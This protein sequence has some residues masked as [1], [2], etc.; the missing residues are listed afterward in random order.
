MRIFASEALLVP[1]GVITAAFLSRQFGPVGY[2]VITLASLIVVWL[3]SNVA[4][5]FSS[6]AIKLINDAADHWQ[7]VG[8]SVIRLYLLAGCGLGL[9]IWGGATPVATLL[10]EP[11]LARYL[12]L[13]ALEIPLFCLAQAHRNIIVGLGQYQQRA[14]ASAARW[15]AR[16]VF[17]VLFVSLTGS[18]VGA[19]WGTICASFIELL[20]CRLYV[21]PSLFNSKAFPLSL[22]CSYAL[23][24]VA[25]AFCLSLFQRLDLLL[26]KLLGGS[27]SDAGLYGAAQNLA[28]LPSLFSF[29]FVPA[30][31]STLNRALRDGDEII[32]R[33]FGQQ[34]IR[35]VLLLLPLI[36]I[37]AGAAPE[38][39]GLIFGRRFI[40]AAPL[41]RL[42]IFGSLA[43]L[44][45]SVA[46]SIM[47]A[48]GKRHF[49]LCIA[50]PLLLAAGAAH[51][52]LIPLRGSLAAAAVTTTGACLGAV[53]SLAIV[54]RLW[55][56][57]LPWAT[58]GRTSLVSAAAYSITALLPNTGFLLPLKI[59]GAVLFA[60]AA[61]YLLGEF[62]AAEINELR[63]I[64]RRY[65]R[66]PSAIVEVPN[67]AS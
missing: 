14:L 30:L 49:M 9:L 57:A 60:V 2:G 41:L 53:A 51:V 1:T 19:I 56:L 15:I 62:S 50:G 13:F 27:A 65:G 23:P 47:T 10:R 45:I 52:L 26:L 22:V 67:Q 37:T 38:L 54:N 17:V 29:A 44:M 21:R 20:I 43:L 58:L 24:L 18:P 61:L 63:L 66:R 28:L 48:A 8:T 25:A 4:M 34:A 64:L 55:R 3:E 5:A 42:L 6:P 32:A 11:E 7:P 35:A 40:A 16:L 31:L 33:Q 36:A 59:A 39:I 12:R 46:F